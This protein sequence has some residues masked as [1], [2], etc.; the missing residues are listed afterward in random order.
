MR[1]RLQALFLAGKQHFDAGRWAEAI[2]PFHEIV[3]IDP[4]NPQAHHDLGMTWLVLRPFGQGGGQPCSGRSNCR[5][6]F[7]SALGHLATALLQVGRE[8]EAL[9]VYR[10]LSGSAEDPVARRFYLALALKTEGRLEEAEQ[11]LRCLHCWGAP[12]GQGAGSARGASVEP[13]HV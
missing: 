6:G 1:E 9:L 13:R 10:R 4:N 3:Q 7:D 2:P 5:P 11:E 8:R 12:H